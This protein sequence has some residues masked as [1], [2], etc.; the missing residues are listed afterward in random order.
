M[1]C[2]VSSCWCHVSS[3]QNKTATGIIIPSLPLTF[4]F[5]LFYSDILLNQSCNLFQEPNRVR[6]RTRNIVKICLRCLLAVYSDCVSIYLS[7][8]PVYLFTAN[9]NTDVMKSFPCFRHCPGW[10]PGAGWW[11]AWWWP[12]PRPWPWPSQRTPTTALRTS[13]PLRLLLVSF[14]R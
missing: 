4:H 2:R 6:I 3:Q 11:G 10:S 9:N 1:N 7:I 14:F 12:P 5:I 13:C 8:Y